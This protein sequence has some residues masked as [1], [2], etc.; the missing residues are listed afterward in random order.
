MQVVKHIF[1]WVIITGY[2][3]VVLGFVY[4]NR[5]KTICN[6]V[7]ISVSDEDM[8]KFLKKEDIFKVLDKYKIKMIG[9]PIDSINTF[10]AEELINKSRA[11]RASAA[12]TTIDGKLNIEVLQRKPILRVTNQRLQNYYLDETGHLIPM[13]KQ[14]SAYTLIANGYIN[15]PFDVTVERNIFTSKKDSIIMP[16]IIYDLF[17]VSNF[18]NKDDFWRSQ[19]EQIYVNKNGDMEMVPRVGSHN[20]IFGKSDDLEIKFR[21]LKA[22]YRAFND[23]GWNQ[24]K[25][26]NLKFKDQ[27]IC[28]KR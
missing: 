21:K 15:E 9:M 14:Y 12:Y 11:V 19:I 24:Y 27:V 26:I 2:L 10:L 13:L 4:E 25:T 7:N 20:I 1:L 5:R 23:I 28:T 17:K 18:I 6:K 16:N 3:I 8:N 22:M